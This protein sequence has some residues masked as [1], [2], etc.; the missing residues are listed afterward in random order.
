MQD[1]E[2]VLEHLVQR[3]EVVRALAVLRRPDVS[4]QLFYK[5]APSLMP[6]SPS[7]VVKLRTADL[8]GIR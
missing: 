1:N 4:A 5:F 8:L 3:G 6:L 7:Q 2:A